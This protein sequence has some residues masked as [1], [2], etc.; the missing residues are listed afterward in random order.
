MAALCLLALSSIWTTP[1][2]GWREIA[3]IVPAMAL[4]LLVTGFNELVGLFLLGVL[5]VGA[6]L[7]LVWRRWD[8]A[9]ALAAVSV[10]TVA[11]LAF[12]F[13]APGTAI[14]AAQD[15]PNQHDLAYA[16][17]LTFLEPDYAP[18]SWLGDARLIWLAIALAS[19]P[20]FLAR[21]P[22]WTNWTLPGPKP[23]SQW[24]VVVPL[25]ALIAVH[26]AALAVNFAQ[27][28]PP[29]LR[30]LNIIYAAFVIGL[31]ASIAAI[32]AAARASL[33]GHPSRFLS[34]VAGIMLP[35]SLVTGPN[36]MRAMADLPKVVTAWRPAIEARDGDIRR[37]AAEGDIKL[38][39]IHDRPPRLFYWYELGS[40]PAEWRNA[41]IARYYGVR[42]IAVPHP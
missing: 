18:A 20:W 10:A 41:C 39:P 9:A 11:G 15:F 12:N 37:R 5:M 2:P 24:L 33:D 34:L 42:S 6:A 31:I 4:A 13:L 3:S 1:R 36:M 29:F 32:G 8:V 27:G 16:I 28:T 23:L 30:V 19:S 25:I 26:L 14:R 38:A 22:A 35:V 40:D 21:L 17:R 7:A